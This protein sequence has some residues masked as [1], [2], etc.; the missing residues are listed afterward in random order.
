MGKIAVVHMVHSVSFRM[1]AW[2]LRD[3]GFEVHAAGS[4]FQPGVEGFNH[5]GGQ[6]RELVCGTME[7]ATT[8]QDALFVDT[9]PKT[10]GRL[11]ALG[12]NG[13][14]LLIWQMPVG[15]EWVRDNLRPRKKVGSL[16][17]SATVGQAV[18]EMNVCPNDAFWPPYYGPLDHS[19]RTSFGDYLVTSVEN[20]AGWSNVPVLEQLRDDPETKLELYGGGP[21]VWSRK[22]P[23]PEFFARLRGALAMYHLKPFDTPGLAVMEAAFQGVPIILPHD[24]IRLTGFGDIFE[25]GRSC[26]V[27]ETRREAVLEVVRRIKETSENERIGREGRRRMLEASDWRINKPRFERLV[28]ATCNA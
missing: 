11:R 19:A 28:T 1:I 15:P 8:P 21:P 25:D 6:G 26:H 20:A 16:A 10:E 17:W 24:W 13:P 22:L 12:W 9:H 23:Q 3:I 4:S 14:L 2:M 27:V 18:R 7:L 5:W